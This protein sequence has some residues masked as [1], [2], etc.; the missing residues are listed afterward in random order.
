VSDLAAYLASFDEEPGYLD[1]ARFGPLSGAV[2]G[3]LL[4]DA[5]ILSTGRRAGIDLVVGN[6]R[7]ARAAVGAL[8]GT[9][10]DHVALQPSTGAGLM[11]V[12]F[13]LRGGILLGR[14][15]FP[16]FP[17]AVQRAADALEALTAHWLD[18]EDG[19]VS[20]DAV[21][22]ALTDD[23]DAVGVSLVD[24][25]TGY[26]ADLA[27]LRDVIGDRLL[28]VDAVQGVG[29][30]DADY[31]AADVV[32]GNGYKWLRAGRG[33]GFAVFSDRALERLTPVFSGAAGAATEKPKNSDA[34]APA[35][36]GTARAFTV[37]RDDELASTRLAAAVGEVRDA[38]VPA[39]A[40]EVASRADELIECAHR[41]GLD[42]LTPSDPRRRAGIVAVEPAPADAA[43]LGA[44]LANSGLT[45]TARGGRIRLAAHAGTKPDTMM[46]LDEALG[47]FSSPQSW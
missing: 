43:R 13:G 37:G 22:D 16:A 24:Y 9:D 27:G 7:S 29:V 40:R 45:V 1:W 8:V 3:E 46:L 34:P 44:A 4:A 25:Q 12:L 6:E 17:I 38:G 2:R 10:A 28:I 42:V 41:H 11:Q 33:T 18:P 39:I 23:I 15:E 14:H 32:C 5:E 35:A 47:A 21:R 30:V 26:L 36:R 19:F 31:A 20:V